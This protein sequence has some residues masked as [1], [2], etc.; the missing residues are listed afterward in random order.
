MRI[1]N[2][3]DIAVGFA[4][5]NPSNYKNRAYLTFLLP[6]TKLLV[7]LFTWSTLMGMFKAYEFEICQKPSSHQTH[8]KGFEP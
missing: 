6:I 4:L 7:H 8:A 5:W 1:V 3:H 2:Y